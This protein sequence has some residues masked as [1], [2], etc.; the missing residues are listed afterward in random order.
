MGAAQ[1]HEQAAYTA[2]RNGT[3]G[4]CMGRAGGTRWQRL[5]QQRRQ[6]QPVGLTCV[7]N[8]PG[9]LGGA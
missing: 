3:G 2:R 7:E 4:W 5:Q 1:C 6:R 8:A 9:L